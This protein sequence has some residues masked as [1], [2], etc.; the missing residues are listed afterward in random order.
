MKV[1]KSGD[2]YHVRVEELLPC[3]RFS[4]C[5]ELMSCATSVWCPDGCFDTNRYTGFCIPKCI[6]CV[7]YPVGCEEWKK[8]PEKHDHSALSPHSPD[9]TPKNKNYVENDKTES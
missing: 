8:L 1:M 5:H 3:K 2:R 4:C 6:D 9:R 7:H